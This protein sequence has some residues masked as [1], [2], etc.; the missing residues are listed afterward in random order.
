MIHVITSGIDQTTFIKAL[1]EYLKSR[2]EKPVIINFGDI[3]TEDYGYIDRSLSLECPI[4]LVSSPDQILY[5]LR[6]TEA[7]FA[8][9]HSVTPDQ[10]TYRQIAELK[11]EVEALNQKFCFLLS[12]RLFG[13]VKG[14]DSIIIPVL[15]DKFGDLPLI[16]W[17]SYL[18]DRS[19]S[20]N[21]SKRLFDKLDSLFYDLHVFLNFK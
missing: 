17:V 15:R 16:D 14:A 11:I 20:L 5:W 3:D 12:E 21:L 13:M 1:E 2:G 8:W 18:C 10:A 19:S 4:A 7:D 6:S 9:Y